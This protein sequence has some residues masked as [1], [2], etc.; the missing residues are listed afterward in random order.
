MKLIINSQP[1][2]LP[3][4]ATISIER[5]S[6]ALNENVGSFSYPFPVPT[7]PNQ[8]LLGWPGDLKRLGVIPNKSFIL[9]DNGIQALRGEVEYDTVTAEEIGV[10]L[11]SGL[12][13]FY[14]LVINDNLE[15]NGSSLAD[16]AWGQ[17]EWFSAQPVTY[18]MFCAKIDEWND[19]NRATNSPFVV[20]P[21]RLINDAGTIIL[22]N[23]HT[24][25]GY[26]DPEFWNE[27]VGV[28]YYY[29]F[30]FRAWYMIEKIFET[31][32]YTVILDELKDGDFAGLVILTR[33]FGMTK[34]TLTE[35]AFPDAGANDFFIYPFADHLEY[36]HLMPDI[37]T[38]DFLNEMKTLMGLFFDIDDLKKE[39]KIMM[40]KTAV[41]TG[42][43]GID[44]PELSGWSHKEA[45][46]N[47]TATGYSLSYITQDDELDNRSDYTLGATVATIAELPIGMPE[48]FVCR[49][50][51]VNRDYI[52]G[53]YP[54][55]N[56]S[57]NAY[58]W[59]EIGR[60]KAKT[61][62]KES[63]KIEFNVKVPQ[64]H[65][66]HRDEDN[67]YPSFFTGPNIPIAAGFVE[68]DMVLYP[69]S[70]IYAS[71]YRGMITNL[72]I[73]DIPYQADPMP[74]LSADRYIS[75]ITVDLSPETLYTLIYADYLTW[76]ASNAKEFTKYVKLTLPQLLSLQWGKRYTVGGVKVVLSKIS[77]EFPFTGIVKIDGYVV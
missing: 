38:I 1:I 29:M 40:L 63:T 60:L 10:I 13:E 25:A 4:D 6:P 21:F 43:E 35:E 16:L 44:L 50:T 9:E 34:N 3:A 7:R 45:S 8:R 27:A 42:E 54:T 75:T 39:V 2:S 70:G 65:Q 53:M 71:L 33:P 47:T 74:V 37:K 36:A 66:S 73:T 51:N 19:A 20:A 59:K 17:E 76:K 46:P 18:A 49:V 11:K 26:L 23:K 41:S 31:Y 15:D 62:G 32:G 12:T 57:Y 67:Q 61:S 5:S 64:G 58:F 28:Y 22:G 68:F 56:P 55:D 14:S 69:M 48:G 77:Y 52:A 30:Q 24:S 72:I